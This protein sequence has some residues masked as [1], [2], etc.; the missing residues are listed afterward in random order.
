M[1]AMLPEVFKSCESLESPESLK[2]PESLKS[3]KS[4]TS[5]KISL[6]YHRADGNDPRGDLLFLEIIHQI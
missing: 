5:P 4:L 1:L 3:P 6:K 2:P